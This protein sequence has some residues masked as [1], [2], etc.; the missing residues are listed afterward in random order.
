MVELL[1]P[2]ADSLSVPSPV[3]EEG[4]GGVPVGL[5]LVGKSPKLSLA[6]IVEGWNWCV[7]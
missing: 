1:C 2:L 3:E 6:T 7:A 5:C 4:E